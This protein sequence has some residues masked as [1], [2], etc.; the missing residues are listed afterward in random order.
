MRPVHPTRLA[1]A[2]LACARLACIGLACAV[3]AGCRSYVEAPVDVG[4]MLAHTSGERALSQRLGKSPHTCVDA[5][6]AH[7]VCSWELGARDAA[8]PEISGA[9]GIEQKVG[10]VC[11][12]PVDDGGG[13]LNRCTTTVRARHSLAASLARARGTL[14]DRAPTLLPDDAHAARAAIDA[15]RTVGE[16]SFVLGEAPRQCLR[17]RADEIECH[18]WITSRSAG[19]RIAATAADSSSKLAVVC[20]FPFDGSPRP[21]SNVC[22]IRES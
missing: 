5:D 19:Y 17:K 12:V 3:L 13:E 15:A 9:M 8:W 1:C 6:V 16:L 20:T 10:V 7:R 18:W 4:S 11:V 2:R 21:A 22:R 14:G